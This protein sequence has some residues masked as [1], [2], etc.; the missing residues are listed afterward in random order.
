MVRRYHELATTVLVEHVVEWAHHSKACSIVRDALRI[1]FART[2]RRTPDDTLLSMLVSKLTSAEDFPKLLASAPWTVTALLLFGS[3][4]AVRDKVTQ[5][6]LKM[7]EED[8][9]FAKK[10]LR[11]F[12]EAYACT[13]GDGG[14]QSIQE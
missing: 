1:G 8:G 13:L 2:M 11:K 10:G 4:P 3:N 14:T 9:K 7:V 5:L 12:L 6:V